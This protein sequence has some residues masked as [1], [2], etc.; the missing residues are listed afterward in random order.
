MVTLGLT[1]AFEIEGVKVVLHYAI[2]RATCVATA[3]F[4]ALQLHWYGCYTYTIIRATCLA[5]LAKLTADFK[6]CPK[7][8]C[9]IN[10]LSRHRYYLLHSFKFPEH[11]GSKTFL[12]SS[13]DM[14]KRCESSRVSSNFFLLVL[15]L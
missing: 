6:R 4:V 10:F 11:R 9:L 15:S 14:C 8:Q 3:E 5:I 2:F 1:T 7:T 12:M 13:T